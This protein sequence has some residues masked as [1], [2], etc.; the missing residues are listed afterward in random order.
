[1]LIIPRRFP[2]Y[3]SKEGVVLSVKQESFQRTPLDRVKTMSWMKNVLERKLYPEGDDVLL[4]NVFDE[5]L[6]SCTAN[7]FFVK[8]RTLIT[9]N[10]PVILSGITRQFLLNQKDKLGFEVRHER[11]TVDDLDDMDDLFLTNSSR[12]VFKVKSV[13]DYPHLKSG[14]VT[15]EVQARYSVL[16]QD[17]INQGTNIFKSL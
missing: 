8:G 7:V 14:S 3:T 6:E 10:S 1:M 11:V 16:I 17:H 4:Y 9:P 15:E 13:I 12:G 2:E 5:V